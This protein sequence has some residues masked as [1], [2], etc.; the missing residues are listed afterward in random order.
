M[1]ASVLRA[2]PLVNGA[3][4]GVLVIAATMEISAIRAVLFLTFSDKDVVAVWKTG[5]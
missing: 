3:S 4:Y 2:D 1:T 5:H